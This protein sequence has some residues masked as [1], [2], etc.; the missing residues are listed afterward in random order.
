MSCG[1]GHRHSSHLTPSLGT[2]L[3]CECSPKKQKKKKKKTKNLI[4]WQEKCSLHLNYPILDFIIFV[5]S[6]E[7]T[8]GLT[9]VVWELINHL[10]PFV[11][12]LF[13]VLEYLS[14]MV[15]SRNGL[16]A[17]RRGRIRSGRLRK[18]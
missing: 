2:S 1:V 12:I 11:L 3:C 17:E 13:N 8:L 14:E 9:Q 5:Y 4:I 16:V 6:V 18:N 15:L 10:G 7:V